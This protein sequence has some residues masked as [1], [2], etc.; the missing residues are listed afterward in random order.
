[1]YV[2]NARTVYNMIIEWLVLKVNQSLLQIHYSSVFCSFLLRRL[3]LFFFFPFNGKKNKVKVCSKHKGS[4]SSTVRYLCIS[5][6]LTLKD[7]SWS[8]PSPFVKIMLTQVQQRE[9]SQILAMGLL[10]TKGL[11][12]IQ[13]WTQR[14]PFP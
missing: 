6:F 7:L 13:M 5:S 4:Y 2:I 12:P 10:G 3:H 9:T 8:N 14:R 11:T 1:M